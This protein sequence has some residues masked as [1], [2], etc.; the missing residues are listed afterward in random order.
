MSVEVVAFDVDGTLTVRD[1]VVPFMR[2]VGGVRALASTCLSNMRTILKLLK[3]R[4]RDSL[5]AVFVWGVFAG[6]DVE[7]VREEGARFALRVADG[8]MRADVAGRLRNHQ[9][10]GSVV[11]LISAS[12]E[13]YLAPLGDMLGVDAVLCTE[14]EVDGT[15][16]SGALKGPNCRG[17]EKV[18]RLRR[19]MEEAGLDADTRVVAYG[20]SAGDADLLAFATVG[21]NVRRIDLNAVGVA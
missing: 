3:A 2:R 16:F 8:W 14:L 1:C 15:K 18:V 13:P 21:T 6:A 17:P 7:A 19:W 5:K 20:D 9:E 12:L 4:D 10:A 11:V